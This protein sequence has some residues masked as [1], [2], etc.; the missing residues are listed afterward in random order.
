MRYSD[1]ANKTAGVLTVMAKF[2]GSLPPQIVEFHITQHPTIAR[3]ASSALDRDK[4]IPPTICWVL[5]RLYGL[6]HEIIQSSEEHLQELPNLKYVVLERRE[7]EMKSENVSLGRLQEQGRFIE[8]LCDEGQ[9]YWMEAAEEVDM[10]A[11]KRQPFLPV[12]PYW[13][14]NT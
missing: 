12:S 4:E 6:R 9:E 13:C 8:R 10:L 5:F 3:E 1:L 11:I 2:P 14:Y 7:W